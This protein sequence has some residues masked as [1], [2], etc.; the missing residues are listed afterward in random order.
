[1]LAGLRQHVTYANVVTTLCLFIVLG[2]SSY[3]AVAL[4]RNSVRSAHIKNGQVKRPDVAR[5]AIDSSKVRNGSLLNQDFAPGQLPAGA[6]GPPGPAGAQGPAGTDGAQGVQG[7]PGSALAFAA[8][9]SNGNVEESRSKNITDANV[10]RPS[11]GLY[12]F[13]NLAFTPQNVVATPRAQLNTWISATLGGGFDCEA[14]DDAVIKTGASG[15]TTT[16]DRNFS[17]LFN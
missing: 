13:D 15:S 6:Q 9:D 1:M 3:A 7:P 2:G 8:V 10:T 17:V 12:C 11:A 5:N 14:D 4:K 16:V